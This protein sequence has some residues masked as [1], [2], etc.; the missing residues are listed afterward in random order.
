MPSE[1]EIIFPVRPLGD[2]NA[3]DSVEDLRS[4]DS[5]D[6][7]ANT[8]IVVADVGIYKYDPSSLAEDDGSEV[9]KPDDKTELQA[10]RWLLVLAASENLVDALKLP[11][12]YYRTPFT[13]P[14][15]IYGFVDSFF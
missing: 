2:Q 13:I 3:I 7:N 5:T 8:N 12:V 6:V 4:L 10:G 14:G 11:A 9:I 1:V 15:S